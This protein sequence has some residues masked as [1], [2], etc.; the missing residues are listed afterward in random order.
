VVFHGVREHVGE[1][2]GLALESLAL[3]FGLH[4]AIARGR[5][6]RLGHRSQFRGVVVGPSDPRA[7]G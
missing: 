5:R 6:R 7:R 1:D 3:V 2:V 4:A